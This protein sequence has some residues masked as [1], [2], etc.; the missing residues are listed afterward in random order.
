MV[1]IGDNRIAFS[2]IVSII[3]LTFL[4]ENIPA[5][6]QLCRAILSELPLTAVI[7]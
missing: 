7:F 1:L 6:C 5:G 4:D 2:F 3:I